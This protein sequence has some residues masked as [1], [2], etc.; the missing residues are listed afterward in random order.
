MTT[1]TPTPA[2]RVRV[3]RPDSE[4]PPVAAVA[5][6]ETTPTASGPGLR[7]AMGFVF[8]WA[9]FDKLFG[10]GYATPTNKGWL[11]GGSPT[12]GFLSHVAVG[13]LE[14]TL[15]SWAGDW[16][17]DWLF[18]LGLLGIGIALTFGI[19]MRIAAGATIVMMALMWI[20]EW[21]LARHTSG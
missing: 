12:K 15:H 20:A 11:D 19:A 9:F 1:I 21:P 17:A 14:S 13:P 16:W 10:F 8:L 6:A 4:P 3:D 5:P 18:M 7:I 2:T